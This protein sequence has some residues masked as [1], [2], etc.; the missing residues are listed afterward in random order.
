MYSESDARKTRSLTICLIMVLSSL[1]PVASADHMNYGDGHLN[2]HTTLF[3][4]GAEYETIGIPFWGD[5]ECYPHSDEQGDVYGYECEE[6]DDNGD[7]IGGWWFEDCDDSTGTW[8]CIWQEVMP[9]YEHGNHTIEFEVTDLETEVDVELHVEIWTFDIFDT[10][11]NWNYDATLNTTT[12]G[13]VDM[14]AYLITENSTCQGEIN[15]HGYIWSAVNGS[16]ESDWFEIGHKRWDFNG[17]CEGEGHLS[18]EYDGVNWE[19]IENDFD[20]EILDCDLIEGGWYCEIDWDM[21]GNTDD[22]HLLHDCEED[23]TTGDWVCVANYMH[24]LLMGG[25]HSMEIMA[26]DLPANGNYSLEIR[27]EAHEDMSMSDW[28]LP[29]VYFN[30]SAAN[31]EYFPFSFETSNFTCWAGVSAELRSGDWDATGNFMEH[32]IIENGR[33]GFDGPCEMRPSP[34][35]LTIDGVDW[36]YI[37]H[38]ED[39]DNCSPDVEDGWFICWHDEWDEDSDGLPD[40]WD[41]TND[42]EEDA[43]TGTW[44]CLVDIQDPFI[45]SG[46]HSIV[47][48]VDE[49]EAGSY[50]LNSGLSHYSND[51]EYDSVWGD[52][53]QIMFNVTTGSNWS[54]QT[55]LE[56]S[57]YTC[58]LHFWFELSTVS[59]T[60]GTD[61]H[62]NG[63][64]YID[65]FHY[66][67]PCDSPPSKFTLTTDG[68]EWEPAWDSSEFSECEEIETDFLCW[69]DYWDEDGDG[70]P[71]HS[72]WQE[73]CEEDATTG[74]W[75]CQSWWEHPEIEEGNHTM[76][77]SYEGLEVGESYQFIIE[78]TGDY[79]VDSGMANCNDNFEFEFNATAETMS[80]T[81]HIETSNYTCFLGIEVSLSSGGYY[82][83]NM[84]SWVGWDWMDSHGFGYK[85]PCEEPPSPF[86]LTYDGIE[87]EP[88]W[89]YEEYDNCSEDGE[90]GWFICWNDEWVD[91]ENGEPYHWDHVV[92]CEEDATTGTWM[93]QPWM[94]NPVI[95]EGN[96]TMELSVD[97][98][99]VGETYQLEINYEICQV[100]FGCDWEYLQFEFNATAETMS[101]TFYMVTDNFTCGVNVD[102]NLHE[103]HD[104]GGSFYLAQQWFGFS[105]PC[106]M[107]PSP[108]TLTYDGIEWEPEWHYGNYDHCEIID[109]GYFA[110][111]QDDWDEDGDGEPDWYSDHED[112][113]QAADGS[114]DC[115]TWWEA[116]YIEEG[117]HTMELSVDSLVVGETYQ[118]VIGYEACQNSQGCGH[119]GVWTEIEFNATAETMSETFYMVTDNYTCEA[120]IDTHIGVMQE[121]GWFLGMMEDH[122]PF[123]GPCE[124][125]PSPFTLTA[126]GVEWELE[127]HYENYDHCEITD[128]GYFACWHDEWD[129]DGDGEPEYWNG[130][131]NCFQREAADDDSW[132]CQTWS[133]AP[134]IEEGTHTMELSVD[135][136]EVGTNYRIDISW[137]ICQK[138]LGCDWDDL[139]FEFNA[140]AET[141]SE[142]FYMETDNFTCG[143]GINV[144]LFTVSE[145]GWSDW[146]GG[147]HFHYNGPCEEP[148]SPFTLTADGVEWEENWHYNNYDY[149]SEDDEGSFNCWND[150]WD[151]TDQLDICE[152]AADGSWDCQSWW[153]QPWIEEGNH[154]MELSVDSL[155]VGTNYSLRISFETYESDGWGDTQEE[156]EIE[157]TA[158]AET[159]SETFYMETSNYTCQVNI[160]TEIIEVQDEGHRE[161][162]G[163][164]YFGYS[165]PCDEPPSPFTL[166]YEGQ[167]YV[168]ERETLYFDNCDEEAHQGSEM[169]CW[170]DMWD[171]DD[172]GYP[173]IWYMWVDEDDCEQAADGSWACDSPWSFYPDIEEGDHTMVLS[174][175]SLVVGTNYSMNVYLEYWDGE[176]WFGD[177]MYFEFNATAETASETFSMVTDNFTCRATVLV[178]MYELRDGHVYWYGSDHFVFSGPCE[179]GDQYDD[180]NEDGGGLDDRLSLEFDEGT[181]TGPVEWSLVEIES[182]YD[183]C[184]AAGEGESVC[185]TEGMGYMEWENDCEEGTDGWVCYEYEP[186]EVGAA[187]LGMTWT[188]E[189]LEIGE[190]YT[191]VWNYCT[192][193]STGEDWCAH[194]DDDGQ[195]GDPSWVNFTATSS[196]YSEDWGLSVANTTC[197]VEIEWA[198][199]HFDGEHDFESDED[200]F[201]AFSEGELVIDGP[202]QWEF[203]VDISL[204]VVS[205]SE[206]QEILGIDIND[207]FDVLGEGEGDGEDG[208]DEISIEVLQFLF[209]N[210]GYQLSE[211]NWSM[212]WTLDGLEV[213]HEYALEWE[214]G[215]EE[216]SENRMFVC[217]DGDVIEFEYVND[218]E[219]D[220]ED[221]A[222]EQ[223]YDENGDPINWFDCFDGSQI[224]VYQV[225]DGTEDCPDGDDEL[226]GTIEFEQ[227]SYF[228]ADSDVMTID[229]ELE[230][231]SG[232]CMVVINAEL[233]DNDD[234][235]TLGW[236]LAVIVGD[237]WTDDNGDNWPDCMPQGDDGDGPGWDVED[238]ATGQDYT[239]ELGFVDSANGTA[240]VSIAQHTTLDDEFR[241]KVDFDFFNG[242]GVLNETEAS[243][244]EMMF[245]Q[246]FQQGLGEECDDSE[247]IGNFTLNGISFWCAE[248][249]MHFQNLA[250]NS[251]GDSPVLLS[252]WYLH[253]NVSIDDSGQM[254]LYF[255]GD[256]GGDGGLDFNGTLCGG[257]HPGSG[258]VPVSWM[259]NNST[260]T[261]LCAEVM[262][263]DAI[264]SIEIIFG[265]PDSDGDGFNDFDDKFPDDATEWADADDDGVGDNSDAFPNDSSET[266]DTDGD[267]VGDNAD[268]FPNDANEFLD[269]DGDGWGDNSDDFP[270]DAN[271]TSDADGDGVGDNA[272]AFPWDPTETAD[273]DGD[274]WGDNSDAFPTDSTEWVDT[275]GDNIGDN[276]DTDADGDGTNDDQEDSDGDGVNDDQ[277]AFPFDEN[278][279]VDTDGDGVGDN[280]DAFPTN[281]SETTDTDGDG[282]GDN[283]DDDADGDGTPNGF[284]D[285]PLNPAV[286]T[287]TDG[288]GVGDAE[289]AFPNDANEYLDTDG[290]GIGDNADTDDD[291]DGTPD[292]SDAFPTDASETTDTDGDGYG[293][294]S[295]LFPNDAGEW[296]DYDGDGV[297]DNSDAFMSDP[298]ESRDSDGD[299]AGDNSD[300]APNDPNEKVDSDGDGVGN[301]A[302]A[303]PTDASE[304][305][306]TD[307]DGIGDNADDDADGDGIPDEGVDDP[308]DDD[309][310]GILPGFT[311][312]T[313]LASVL[314]AAILVAGRRK[315]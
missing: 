121:E 158:T 174:V 8:T 239:A 257:A 236:F 142:T 254:T 89:H 269:S 12:A 186:P 124:V 202:C 129:E 185:M 77:L 251:N 248:S 230:V 111:W 20:G 49:L 15:I 35:T 277:D 100:M 211:G 278:E 161:G 98:L 173:D 93:C 290:D 271:E 37:E 212:S 3:V 299:G 261:D 183:G 88:E 92:D 154:T 66:R 225:N 196:E 10:H 141:A 52:S 170:Q 243:T 94:V 301:N 21:D 108:F 80:E 160:H 309:D 91:S 218:D 7:A 72:S 172:D 70:E 184:W 47:L 182:H 203:P 36:E 104:D 270:N 311:A 87:W 86:T 133:E 295:D 213:G 224:W 267:G 193:S 69:Q 60:N 210:V 51:D 219:Q 190:N 67:A 106:E 115:T 2:M 300:W 221:G 120:H 63:T 127:W 125:P 279:T 13:E 171:S 191:I 307:G 149:C 256:D 168:E 220:C 11:Q 229:W 109:G 90:D 294:N 76:E 33:F 273:S 82:A 207:L 263:G 262:A 119:H 147:D 103:I 26:E 73:S 291:D 81:F 233:W 255:P 302:D 250:N 30:G 240:I 107:P 194:W 281:A 138:M 222:D 200:V 110:C 208:P 247:D 102:V 282:I 252:G 9:M 62:T 175:D 74:T 46:N 306:D 43:T 84:S 238:F 39:Y 23:A 112:C 260:I 41:H 178:E 118:L 85:G 274:G 61:Y 162:I 132:D 28:T 206:Y 14:T 245:Q 209:D 55:F 296:S 265:S 53:S 155:E 303:F 228:E 99:E 188:L 276:A 96:H 45:Y 1:G 198:W 214:V 130:Q 137:D 136:L 280:A 292:T 215:W 275:D 201:I 293:D 204:E 122:F 157:F 231:P 195:D 27:L 298:Y 164:D 6:I 54:E 165:G 57:N 246:G 249:H 116:P 19:E 40:H 199:V 179:G 259:Y 285:F 237:M 32:D 226:G 83:D 241:M 34:F 189:D 56:T 235:N 134:E 176:D 163:Y 167:E 78:T 244:M 139:Q 152:E 312:A 113:E 217:G 181:G 187:E 79:C 97:S 192:Q 5:L 314:G 242:D 315:D 305:T 150:G 258:L 117:N 123:S 287:D 22:I 146:T 95:E 180:W 159:A 283:S 71:E 58:G 145:D 156:F 126:D 288:D 223:Q 266:A 29:K 50:M 268:A 65:E 308:T 153:E 16:N 25:T 64:I 75:M 310:G 24:P 286:S 253:F 140:T 135:S 42:C 205:E 313:G 114:W 101:E 144:N 227:D 177:E 151:W 68:V 44:W 234:E 289:D 128:E 284:D 264:G 31:A 304:T 38:Y 18:L 48:T 143:V 197:E 166:T 17:P 232:L 131:Q 297:G 59:W 148:P 216:D 169:R 272:D 105:G 4:D